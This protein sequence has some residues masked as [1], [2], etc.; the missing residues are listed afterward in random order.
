MTAFQVRGRPSWV[1]VF[2][3]HRAFKLW[4][5][6]WVMHL[7]FWTRKVRRHPLPNS[8][9]CLTCTLLALS[10]TDCRAV[11]EFKKKGV[12]NEIMY[13]LWRGK[14]CWDGAG[15][16]HKMERSAPDTD[17]PI[18]PFGSGHCWTVPRQ[19]PGFACSERVQRMGQGR[20]NN[21]IKWLGVV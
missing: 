14:V 20:A 17:L 11:F 16:R 15:G 19:Y 13:H 2:L 7:C 21:K 3:H 18:A 1:L 10:Q 12:W 9:G 8:A 6:H 4:D 5:G